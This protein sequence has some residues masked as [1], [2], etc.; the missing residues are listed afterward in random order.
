MNRLKELRQESNLSL[1]D[2]SKYVGIGESTLNLIENDKREL[3][4]TKI[5][6]LADF[7]NITCDYL[8]MKSERGIFIESNGEMLEFTR[9]ELRALRQKNKIKYRIIEKDKSYFLIRETTAFSEGKVNEL[10]EKLASYITDMD[11]DQI[12]KLLNFYNDYLK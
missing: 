5:E 9:N 4:S 10:R 6:K 11:S 1:K 7:F 3:N 12:K 2:L 8:L